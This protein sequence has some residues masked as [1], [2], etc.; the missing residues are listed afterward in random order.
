MTKTK[1]DLMLATCRLIFDHTNPA[2]ME[3]FKRDALPFF[4]QNCPSLSKPITDDEFDREVAKIRENLPGIIE[5]LR[6]RPLPAA[7]MTGKDPERN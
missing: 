6:S 7:I 5:Y 2:A 4:L 3:E 1:K